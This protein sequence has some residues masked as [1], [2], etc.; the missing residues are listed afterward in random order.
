[1][2]DVSKDLFAEIMKENEITVSWLGY[3]TEI[4]ER[5][6]YN[7]LSGVGAIHISLWAALYEA[8]SDQR[9]LELLTGD[10]PFEVVPLPATNIEDCQQATLKHLCEMRKSQL[11]CET[12]ILETI[13]DGKINQE[14]AASVKE[15]K[16]QHPES[17]KLQ[18][19][20]YNTIL[21]SYKK[22]LKDP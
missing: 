17:L 3:K 16:K 11:A 10:V 1:M 12:A 13:K 19:Q 5:T 15:L 9:I 2:E 18:M 7:Q 22:S 14:D 20:L 6:I 4:P 21:S 8:T